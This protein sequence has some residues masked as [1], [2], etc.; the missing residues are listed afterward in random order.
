MHAKEGMINKNG[1]NI[2]RCYFWVV[3][4]QMRFV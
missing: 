1:Q 4:L 3:G 2:N